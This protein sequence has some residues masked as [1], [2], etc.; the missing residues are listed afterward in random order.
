MTAATWGLVIAAFAACFVEMVEATT[1]VMAMGFTRGW[2]SALIG[3]A[4][5]IGHGMDTI[6][7]GMYLN[8]RP[9]L[10]ERPRPS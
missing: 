8:Q 6:E 2:R 5:A 1:I 9:E 10:L 3:T 4:A 7:H